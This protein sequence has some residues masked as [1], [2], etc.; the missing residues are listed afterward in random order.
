MLNVKKKKKKRLNRAA[1]DQKL[2]EKYL[3]M[4]QYLCK[5][6]FLSKRK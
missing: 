3:N 4:H 6:H 2:K 1:K 5:F